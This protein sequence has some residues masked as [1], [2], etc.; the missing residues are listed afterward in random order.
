MA[1]M[2]LLHEIT[3]LSFFF[4]R[5]HSIYR[6]DFAQV[7]HRNLF[8]CK[9]VSTLKHFQRNTVSQANNRTPHVAEKYMIDAIRQRIKA[10]F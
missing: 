10:T 3:L 5:N 9:F 8:V 6:T 7:L 2:F 4:I 1:H